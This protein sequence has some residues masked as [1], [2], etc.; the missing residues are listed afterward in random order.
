MQ[1][2]NTQKIIILKIAANNVTFKFLCFFFFLQITNLRFQ[3]NNIKINKI[4]FKKNYQL[5]NK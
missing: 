3:L 2:L 4:Y 5:K 1:I